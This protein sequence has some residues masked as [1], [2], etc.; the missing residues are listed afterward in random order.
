[1]IV[2]NIIRMKGTYPMRMA[3]YYFS[4]PDGLQKVLTALN[5]LCA[6][7]RGVHIRKPGLKK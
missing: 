6:P 5:T 2:V 4:E 3:T 7:G 1:M